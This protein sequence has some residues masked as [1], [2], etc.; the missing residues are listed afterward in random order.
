[1]IFLSIITEHIN[2]EKNIKI[3]KRNKYIFIFFNI[4]VKKII[5]VPTKNNK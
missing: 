2:I 1:M 4:I 5:K 3:E